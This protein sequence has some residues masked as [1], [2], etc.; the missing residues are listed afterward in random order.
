M[1]VTREADHGGR[2]Q[3]IASPSSGK[4]GYFTSGSGVLRDCGFDSVAVI[5]RFPGAAD[6]VPDAGGPP[7]PQAGPPA[8]P[9]RSAGFEGETASGAVGSST[10]S[11]ILGVDGQRVRLRQCRQPARRRGKKGRKPHERRRHRPRVCSIGS[12]TATYRSRFGVETSYYQSLVSIRTTTTRFAVWFL[13]WRSGSDAEP[14][15]APPSRRTFPSPH[16]A[17]S[18]QV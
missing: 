2:D 11:V 17:L 3:G 1:A 15:G 10:P 8:G 13:T 14:V 5:P 12:C 9:Q 6:A 4:A 18:S 16:R 7:R